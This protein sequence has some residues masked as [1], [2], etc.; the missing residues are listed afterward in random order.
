MKI[1]IICMIGIGMKVSDCC[2]AKLI[3]TE[4]QICSKCK[5]HCEGVDE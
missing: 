2:N 3:E 1:L 5:E 4:S